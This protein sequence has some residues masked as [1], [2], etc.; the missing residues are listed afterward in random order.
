MYTVYILNSQRVS[1]LNYDT[2]LLISLATL[3]SS[4]S[5]DNNDVY[6]G[7][8][9]KIL[10]IYTTKGLQTSKG[11]R[12]CNCRTVLC[13]QQI[14]IR[15]CQWFI[16]N[17]SISCCLDCT[18]HI[19]LLRISITFSLPMNLPDASYMQALTNYAKKIACYSILLCSEFCL[20]FQNACKTVP[21]IILALCS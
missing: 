18:M 15:H 19:N 4:G 17:Y 6:H 21:I 10:C 14:Q 13:T 12:A 20:L 2:Q 8:L 7:Q 9:I 11:K 16:T 1:S 5:L 3:A